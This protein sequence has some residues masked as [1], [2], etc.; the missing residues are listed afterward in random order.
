[1]NSWRSAKLGGGL[2]TLAPPSGSPNTY[3]GDTTVTAGTLEAE[4]TAALP[5]YAASPAKVTVQ[6]A[7]TLAVAV[8]GQNEWNATTDEIATLLGHASFAAGAMLGIDTPNATGAAFTYPYDSAVALCKL[9]S[10]KLILSGDTA[11][12]PVRPS[13]VVHCRLSTPWHWPAAV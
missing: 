10:G 4:S 3:S 7:A 8:G 1:M 9:G 5:G 2:L 6:P 11:Y 13:T 12:V